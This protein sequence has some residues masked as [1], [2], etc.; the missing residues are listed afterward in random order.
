MYRNQKVEKRR[1]TPPGFKGTVLAIASAALI[2][3]GASAADLRVGLSTEVD[4]LDPQYDYEISDVALHLHL[5]DS[6]ILTDE[7]QRLVPGLATSWK[8]VNDKTWEFSLRKGVKFHDGTNFDAQDVVF[9]IDRVKTLKALTS[10]KMFVQ[11]IAKMSVVDS[12]TIRFTTKDVYPLLPGDLSQ[13]MIVSDSI[14]SKASTAD[15]NSGKAAIGT[16]PYKLVKF[17]PGNRVV[18]EANVNY[19]GGRPA[20]DKVTNRMI[21]NAGARMAALLAGDLDVI[22]KVPTADVARLKADPKVRLSQSSSNRVIYLH[23]DT[24]RDQSPNVKDKQGNILPNNPLKDLRVRQAISK[25]INRPAI[26][27]RVMETLAIPAGQ[28]LPEG[29]F[30]I[31]PRLNPDTYNPDAAKKLL[32]AAGY[33]NGFSLTI[34]GPNNRYINDHKIVQAV[35]QMLSQV[36]IDTKVD[37]MPKNV[38]WP[39][40]N[41]LDFSLMLVGWGSGANAAVNALKSLLATWDK[42]KGM[43]ST[44]RGRYSNSEFDRLLTEALRTVD[45][46]KQEDLLIKATELGIGEL[47]IIPLHYQVNTWGTRKGLVCTA[48]TDEMTLITGCKPAS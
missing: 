28:L 23:I 43:G 7:K 48:R 9:S 44:N 34:H 41:N 27:E 46:K 21:T 37:T 6:L 11:N 30:G 19:W 13:V 38:Y 36:G 12:H 15:F 2:S 29:F 22:E 47:G 3:V 45:E 32:A 8:P 14:G 42:K 1:L 5:Y 39:K 4:S 25:A 10:F 31:S 17:S 35:A 24:N 20:W 18:I 16:G 26:V 33:P 40:A